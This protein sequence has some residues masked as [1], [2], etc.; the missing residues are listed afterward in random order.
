VKN[1]EKYVTIV[2]DYEW[3]HAMQSN[4]VAQAKGSVPEMKLVKEYWPRL[5]ETDF[6]S[7]IT[8]I[9]RDA[10]DFVYGNIADKDHMSFLKQA[11]PYGLFNKSAYTSLVSVTELK[12]LA[13]EIP[14]GLI[15]TSRCAFFFHMDNPLMQTFVKNYLQKYGEH[16]SDWS[17]G[18]Y[19]AVYIV[20]QGIEKG[21]TIESEKVKN[22]MRGMTVETT[23]GKLYFRSIDNQINGPS[24]FGVVKDDPAYPFPIYGERVLIPG[25]ECWRPVKE[26]VEIRKKT[27][28]DK[29]RS[30]EDIPN[31]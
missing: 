24:Y 13:K 6:T 23:R 15:G 19:D 25:E 9:L 20:K 26:I 28:L 31:E 10:P 3:G 18:G 22:A 8:A 4:F 16:P 5:G 14:R 17:V 29:K 2:S 12:V 21:S 27:G 11:K 7:Y 1:W 30:P